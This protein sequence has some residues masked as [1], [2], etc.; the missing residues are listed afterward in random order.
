MNPED[1]GRGG[2]GREGVEGGHEM[3][4]GHAVRDGQPDGTE[5]GKGMR[6]DDAAI[7]LDGSETQHDGQERRLRREGERAE[8]EHGREDDVRERAEVVGHGEHSD[9]RLF[10]CIRKYNLDISYQM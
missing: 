1:G 3:G 9:G 7:G 5:S 10:D 4:E 2:R 6:D 8:G